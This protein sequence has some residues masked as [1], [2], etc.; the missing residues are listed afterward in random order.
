MLILKTFSNHVFPIPE[1]TF[2]SIHPIMNSSIFASSEDPWENGWAAPEDDSR[3]KNTGDSLLYSNPDSSYLT[4]SQL[5]NSEPTTSDSAIPESYKRVYGELGSKIETVDDLKQTIFDKLIKSDILT[6]YQITRIIDILYDYNLLPPSIESN[7]YQILGL[8]ALEIDLAGTGDYVT[9]QFKL[10]TRLPDIADSI[11]E[12]LISNDNTDSEVP[13]VDAEANFID[14]LTSQL[15]E[16]S[17]NDNE[18]ENE[19]SSQPISNTN[20]VGATN[21]ETSILSDPILTDHSSIQQKQTKNEFES[22]NPEPIEYNEITK[23]ID[24]IRDRFKPL[25]NTPNTVRIKEV[26]EKEGLLFKHINYI[27]THDLKLGLHGPAG[28]KKVIRR[29]SDFVWLLEYLLKKYPF[30]VIPGLPPK[31]FSGMYY[32]TFSATHSLEQNTNLQFI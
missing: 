26:P 13:Q 21:K 4:S 9:L 6:N 7:F 2:L 19:W 17:I 16:T 3:A 5:L 20:S 30:R 14:P 31:K 10:N 18:E 15:N 11:I 1:L 27:I 23:Y 29:Y 8:I 24:E 12:L 28:T 22:S 25:V 32:K